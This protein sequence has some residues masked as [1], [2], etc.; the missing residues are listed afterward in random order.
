M[1]LKIKYIDFAYV[2]IRTQIG[3][4]HG[5]GDIVQSWSQ[6]VIW[7]VI[8]RFENGQ[9]S[10]LCTL[11]LQDLG[12]PRV[13]LST[14]QPDQTF[15]AVDCMHAATVVVML[16][17]HTLQSHMQFGG[18]IWSHTSKI[19]FSPWSHTCYSGPSAV[20]ISM[21]CCTVHMQRLRFLIYLAWLLVVPYGRATIST[22]QQ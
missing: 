14:L 5:S 11:K 3:K 19:G 10:N 17:S 6:I 1:L 18:L 2:Q 9:G 22:K 16:K 21:C 13:A 8:S 12:R 20:H 4:L 7:K 15:M